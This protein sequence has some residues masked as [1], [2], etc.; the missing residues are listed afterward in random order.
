[1]IA[2]T[3]EQVRLILLLDAASRAGLVPLDVRTLHTFAYFANVLS[4]VWDMPPM[5]GS[6]LK[7]QDGP[8]YPVLQHELDRLVGIGIAR[9]SNLGHDADD[10]GRWRL[11]GAF[12]LND[13]LAA[14]ILAVIETFEG[15]A[16]VHAFLVELA[17][18]LSG[19]PRE[20]AACASMQDATFA[21]SLTENGNVL[22]FGEWKVRNYSSNA[23]RRF[24]DLTSA[25]IVATQAELLH[26]YVRHLRLRLT[27]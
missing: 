17:L 27:S 23:A 6:V 19:L 21:D 22:D 24:R 5:D 14:P 8:Y 9:I 15:E 4:P 25:G 16:V 12:R 26:L 1:M 3:R 20:L 2:A 10:E 11:R 18:A 13:H 7:M